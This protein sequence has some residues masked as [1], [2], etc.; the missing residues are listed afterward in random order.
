MALAPEGLFAASFFWDGN[1]TYDGEEWVY[2][3]FS[4]FPP[5]WVL[6]CAERQG[7]RAHPLTWAKT[8]NHYW[9][10]FSH[11]EHTRS[12]SWLNTMD[13]EQKMIIILELRREASK[14][15]E[16]YDALKKSAAI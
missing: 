16:K 5:K 4:S 11:Y 10:V 3:H 2:P 12:L 1:N 6:E 7:L 13:G 9:M 14:L 8:Y 15:R